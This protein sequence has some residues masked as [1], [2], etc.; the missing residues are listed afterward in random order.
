MSYCAIDFGTSNSAVALPDPA[1]EAAM[2]LAPV[3]GE[4]RTLPTSI[5]FNTNEGT[6]R[7]RPCRAGLLHRRFRRPAD[8]LDEEEHPRL[9]AGANHHRS[10][11]RQR[12]RLYRGVI[13][14]FMQHIGRRR[15][16]SARAARLLAR[17]SAGRCSSSTTMRVPTASPRSSSW[18]PRAVGEPEGGAFQYEPIA[19]AFDYESCQAA[20]TLV[21]VRRLGRYLGLL[22]G[23]SRLRAHGVA[24]AQGDDALAHHG[25][26]VAVHRL[27][28]RRVE[29]TSIMPAFGYRSL[30]PENRELPNRI[31]FDLATLSIPS[32]RPSRLPSSS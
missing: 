6:R 15:C 9:A 14:I 3:E 7:V 2:R 5:F 16:R 32:T 8:A 28:P 29:L 11:R 18:R 20:E 27:R 12:H 25:V 24:R 31:Y 10:R 26:H 17:C 4:H 13:A 21:L 1:R 30:Y 19:A 22:A 23:A